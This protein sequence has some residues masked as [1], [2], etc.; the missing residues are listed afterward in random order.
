MTPSMLRYAAFS[1]AIMV[2]AAHPVPAQDMPAWTPQTLRMLATL[3]VQD[4]GRIKPLDTVAAFKLLRFNGKRS[5]RNLEGET[6]PPIAWLADCLFHPE[7]ARQYKI[8]RIDNAEVLESLGLPFTKKRDRYA[9]DDLAPASQKLFALAQLYAQKEAKKRTPLENQIV[10]LGGNVREFEALMAYADFTRAPLNVGES[11]TLAALFPG[12]THVSLSVALQKTPDIVQAYLSMKGHAG[13]SVPD[14]LTEMAAMESFMDSVE[15]AAAPAQAFALFPPSGDPKE[16]E[17][18]APSDMLEYMVSGKTLDPSVIELLAAFETLDSLRDNPSGFE[19]Q[20]A[21]FHAALVRLAENRGEY[22]KIP[23]EVCFYRLKLFYYSLVLYIASFLLIACSWLRP[24]GRMLARLGMPAVLLPTAL[25]AAGIA[26]RCIIRG[27][28]PVTTLYE[29]ILFTT[30]VAV[31]ASL[32]IEKVNRQ[33]V[34][35]SL[36]SILGVLG[37]FLANKYELSDGTDTMPSMAAVLDTNF[38]LATHVT[39]I[40]IGYAA[41][42]LAGALGHAYVF[43][44]LLR[45]R[46]H[47]PDFYPS[48]ARMIYGVFCFGLLFSVLGTIL[49]GIWA[50][51]SWG[52]FWGWDPKENGALMIVL[53]QLAVLHARADGLIRDAG[54]ALG[55]ILG[56]VIVTFSW[57]GVNLLGVGLHSYGFTSG[58]FHLLMAFYAVELL[59]VLLGCVAWFRDRRLPGTSSNT[60]T[61]KA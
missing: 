28:P 26:L 46:S 29:T 43:G 39:T 3:P 6:I 49:G 50:A 48:V 42:L 57:F 36:A 20:L 23:L 51:E 11:R 18:L 32:C 27:R 22:G 12:Q 58:T 2:L 25:L 7:L 15:H 14:F 35:L 41:G 4:E 61:D 59:I 1:L 45:W 17:W 8:F 19:G 34:A 31:S 33:R 40:T 5:C 55:A 38:W 52:R 9:Y 37:V 24:Q 54:I 21:V 53:W 30:A 10:Y 47:E 16:T 60:P 13:S 44:R 56:G